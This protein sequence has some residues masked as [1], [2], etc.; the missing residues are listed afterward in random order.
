MYFCV[1]NKK[2][3]YVKKTNKRHKIK[4]RF[5]LILAF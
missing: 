4:K 3:A 5:T 1:S 2:I